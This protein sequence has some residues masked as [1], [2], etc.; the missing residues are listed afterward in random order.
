MIYL[1]Y[2]LRGWTT[3]PLLEHTRLSMGKSHLIKL[4]VLLRQSLCSCRPSRMPTPQTQWWLQTMAI[5]GTIARAILL[6]YRTLSNILI[7]IYI[8]IGIYIYK[9]CQFIC[10]ISNVI[11]KI[12]NVASYLPIIYFC[13]PNID[14]LFNYQPSNMGCYCWE[15]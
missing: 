8:Y 2:W 11:C 15:M 3:A 7:F 12:W 9:S 4:Q 10:H 5:Q 6:V 1:L 13:I 14:L